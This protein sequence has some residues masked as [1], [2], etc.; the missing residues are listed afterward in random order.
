MT[1]TASPGTVRGL[2]E[3]QAALR[4]EAVYALATESTQ[5]LTY[6]DLRA[7]CGR[8]ATLL[9]AQ[10]LASGDTVA[11]IMPNGLTHHFSQSAW[12]A[13]KSQFKLSLVKAAALVT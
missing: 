13:R 12:L 1:D 10:G 3:Q 8:V 5:Q 2:I 6:A 7:G 4:P 9:Q 11:L